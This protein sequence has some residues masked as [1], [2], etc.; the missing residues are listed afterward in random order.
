VNMKCSKQGLDFIKRWEGLRLEIYKDS[1][2][3]DTIGVGHLLTDSDPI[4]RWRNHGIDE[5]EADRLLAID[6]EHAEHCVNSYVSV[7]LRQTD[8]DAL[9]SFTFNLGGHNLKRSTLLKYINNLAFGLAIDEFPR[10]IY[11]SGQKSKGLENR[12][13][14]EA[15]LMLRAVYETF[16]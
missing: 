6:I 12:R 11:A 16:T 5:N 9:V 1:A 10:W 14:A 15:M 3:Y 8:F 4:E 13:T 2:G 7:S